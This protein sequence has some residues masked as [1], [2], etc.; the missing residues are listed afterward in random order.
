MKKAS[1]KTVLKSAARSII[2]ITIIVVTIM[3]MYD[4]SCGYGYG[5]DYDYAVDLLQINLKSLNVWFS[6]LKFWSR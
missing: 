6:S 3:I 4:Y 2:T 5:Y 1:V